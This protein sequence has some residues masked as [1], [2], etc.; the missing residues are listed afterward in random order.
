MYHVLDRHTLLSHFNNVRLYKLHAYSLQ[1]AKA[2]LEEPAKLL[3]AAS[4]PSGGLANATPAAITSLLRFREASLVQSVA[5]AMAAASSS[6]SSG[7][8]GAVAAASQAAFD[9]NLDSVVQI[10]WANVEKFCYENF[11]QAAEK[12]PGAIQ[13][14][15]ALLAKLYGLSRVER[16]VAHYLAAGALSRADAVALRSEVMGCFTVL[17][18]GQGALARGLCDA[19]GI[20]DH[21]LQAPIA[22]DWHEV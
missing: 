6:A 14:A 3:A 11:L 17:L 7:G 16:S 13:P 21:L 22:F 4:V 12:A 2:L 5:V 15:L 20:P 18:A 1:V 8:K 19:W 9:A 10:G